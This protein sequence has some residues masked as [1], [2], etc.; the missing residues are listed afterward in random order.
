MYKD[1]VDVQKI[2]NNNKIVE[3]S[4][5]WLKKNSEHRALIFDGP[6]GFTT[7]TLS[8]SGL[9]PLERITVVE[10]D[11]ETAVKI[12]SLYRRVKLET[13]SLSEIIHNTP[14]KLRNPDILYLD[15]MISG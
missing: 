7:K 8:D 5:M 11:L 9:V 14:E 13:G 1:F 2:K 10:K 12:R 15:Y 3:F 6:L 4:K